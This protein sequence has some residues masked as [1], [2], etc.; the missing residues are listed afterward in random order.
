M[1][2]RHRVCFLILM[3]ACTSLSSCFWSKKPKA[4]QV[5]NPPTPP[6]APAAA[7]A[8][9]PPPKKAGSSPA[10]SKKVPP[11]AA[12]EPAPPP[13]PSPSPPGQLTQILTP[14]EKAQFT[15]SFDRS[16]ASARAALARISG[17]TLTHDQSESVS[18]INAL[19]SQAAAARES[20]LSVAAQLARRAE[21]LARDL[22]N[23]LR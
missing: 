21:L 10:A 22:S 23:S 13:A 9:R 16:T 4:V 12:P 7:P 19:L 11:A 18:L 14:Q 8:P 20:D 3:L 5:P 15:R 17:R 6:P 2:R 1:S